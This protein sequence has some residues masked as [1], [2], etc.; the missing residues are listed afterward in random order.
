MICTKYEV[1]TNIVVAHA[2]Q[3]RKKKLYT[4]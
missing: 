2:L 4:L 3:E 1:Q